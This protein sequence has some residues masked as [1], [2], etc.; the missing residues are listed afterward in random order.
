MGSE[1][2]QLLKKYLQEPFYLNTKE[3]DLRFYK[4]IS[5]RNIPS[6]R[7]LKLIKQTSKKIQQGN[8]E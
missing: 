5:L 1:N 8:P 4:F 6:A 7:N 2:C 3:R